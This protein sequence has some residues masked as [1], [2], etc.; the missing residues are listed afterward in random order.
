MDLGNWALSEAAE[1]RDTKPK[2]RKMPRKADPSSM[3]TDC[4][5]EV[6]SELEV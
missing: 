5:G 4:S 6:M 1:E 2:S 3:I